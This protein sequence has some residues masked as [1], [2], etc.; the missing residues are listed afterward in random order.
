MSEEISKDLLAQQRSLM[1][2]LFDVIRNKLPVI[3]MPPEEL[4]LPEIP[5]LRPLFQPQDTSHT[6]W[7]SENIGWN[8]NK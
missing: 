6:I 3:W 4:F 1:E 5:D 7:L 2:K 8:K